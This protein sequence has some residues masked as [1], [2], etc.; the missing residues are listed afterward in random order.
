MKTFFMWIMNTFFLI[1]K[2]IYMPEKGQ[3]IETLIQITTSY[4]YIYIYAFDLLTKLYKIKKKKRI[5]IHIKR[6][7]E[8]GKKHFQKEF[9]LQKYCTESKKRVYNKNLCGFF[10]LWNGIRART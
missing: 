2:K 1:T 5:Q 6:L 9:I 3:D 10:H 4:I 7:M 8:D